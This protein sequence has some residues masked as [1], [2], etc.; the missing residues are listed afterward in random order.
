MDLFNRVIFRFQAFIFQGEGYL[1]WRYI[2]LSQ[3]VSGG[4][5][6]A[7]DGHKWLTTMVSVGPLSRVSLLINGL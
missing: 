6:Q 3:A 5:D 2:C 4:S 7:H 1:I